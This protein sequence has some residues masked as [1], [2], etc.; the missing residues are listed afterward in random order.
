MRTANSENKDPDLINDLAEV[1]SKTK[2]TSLPLR[3]HNRLVAQK[4]PSQG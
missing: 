1:F 2:V 4:H 3:L